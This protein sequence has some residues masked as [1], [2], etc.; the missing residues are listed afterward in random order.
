MK[1]QRRRDRLL[2]ALLPEETGRGDEQQEHDDPYARLKQIIRRAGGVDTDSVAN[3]VTDLVTLLE[4]DVPDMLAAIKALASRE[5]MRC[6]YCGE[7]W[8]ALLVPASVKDPEHPGKFQCRD[9]DGCE[10][11]LMRA[12]ETVIDAEAARRAGVAP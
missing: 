2:D 6:R 7:N 1:I 4:D 3:V 9:V 12:A 8:D 5:P 11:R 10:I